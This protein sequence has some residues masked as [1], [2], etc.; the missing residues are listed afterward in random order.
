MPRQPDH[1]QPSGQSPSFPDT[2]VTQTC[3]QRALSRD[4]DEH[5][6]SRHRVQTQ[7]NLPWPGTLR[8]QSANELRYVQIDTIMLQPLDCGSQSTGVLDR[9]PQASSKLKRPGKLLK[10]TDA[11]GILPSI[12]FTEEGP[13]HQ[14]FYKALW[15]ILMHS[16]RTESWTQKHRDSKSQP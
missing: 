7:R 1:R 15:V 11:Q 12:Q 5:R 4:T 10:N 2:E 8:S 13:R 6:H 16:L 3:S 14:H 9:G